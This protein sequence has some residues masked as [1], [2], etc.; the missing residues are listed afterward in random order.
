MVIGLTFTFLSITETVLALTSASVKYNVINTRY[1]ENLFRCARIVTSNT[2]VAARR[3]TRR[4]APCK[5]L[6]FSWLETA[7]IDEK[8]SYMT[9]SC[10]SHSLAAKVNID[11]DM[12][13]HG[14]VSF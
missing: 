13:F 5:P 2:Y 11:I 9:K 6:K 14:F 3:R 4:Y 1:G 7:D 12:K 8:Y 10:V